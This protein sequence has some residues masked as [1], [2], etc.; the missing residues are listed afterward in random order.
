MVAISKQPAQF[1]NGPRLVLNHEPERPNVFPPTLIQLDPPKHGVYRQAGEGHEPLEGTVRAA[2][3]AKPCAS[4]PQRRN[5]RNSAA[6]NGGNPIPSVRAA[7]VARKA[8]RCV[9]T[10]AWSTPAVGK[11]GM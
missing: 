8:L 9:C 11:R 6:T 4:T 2:D 3:A 7:T 10:T 1:L 5:F